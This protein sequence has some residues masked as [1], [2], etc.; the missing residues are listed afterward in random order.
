MLFYGAE[1]WT[2]NKTLYDKLDVFKTKKLRMLLGI[3]REKISNAKL[4][5][6]TDQGTMSYNFIHRRQPCK[7]D[8]LQ[9]ITQKVLFGDKEEGKSKGEN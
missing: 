7:S 1:M 8:G 3:R 5:R 9:K 4:Y 2:R 6:R